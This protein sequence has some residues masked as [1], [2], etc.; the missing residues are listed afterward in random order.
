L[1]LLFII[2][3]PAIYYIVSSLPSINA[4]NPNSTAGLPYLL[5]IG[6]IVFL[7]KVPST[8]LPITPDSNLLASLFL[9][10]NLAV[11]SNVPANILSAVLS[12][13]PIAV[14]FIPDKYLPNTLSYARPIPGRTNAYSSISAVIKFI[15]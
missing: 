11:L 5:S 2:S 3:C 1:Y 8:P 6:F 9:N 13:P 12:I 15:F 4:S 10:S 14:F 7:N